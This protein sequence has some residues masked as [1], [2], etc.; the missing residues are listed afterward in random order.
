MTFL[1]AERYMADYYYHYAPVP[2]IPPFDII[3]LLAGTV[4]LATIIIFIGFKYDQGGVDE[5]S[6]GEITTE[7]VY[8]AVAIYLAY[9]VGV[10]GSMP[11]FDFIIHV[12]AYFVLLLLLHLLHR[13]VIRRLDVLYGHVV[14]NWVLGS[15]LLALACF[16]FYRAVAPIVRLDVE[17]PSIVEI[18][19]FYEFWKDVILYVVLGSALLHGGYRGLIFLESERAP[20]LSLNSRIHVFSWYLA[21][22]VLSVVLLFGFGDMT[23]LNTLDDYITAGSAH[24]LKT[25]FDTTNPYIAQFR[26]HVVKTHIYVRDMTLLVFALINSAWVF[27]RLFPGYGRREVTDNR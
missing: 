27:F 16:G 3:Q 5:P 8:T 9:V 6:K 14:S 17:F 1:L 23:H 25:G 4:L 21:V 12:A 19:Q 18:D 7:F 11:F 20:G 26:H 22:V 13:L 2:A 15:A 24:A 10:L